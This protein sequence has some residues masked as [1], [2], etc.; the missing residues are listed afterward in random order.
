MRRSSW[1]G[2]VS[3]PALTQESMCWTSPPAGLTAW[4]ST[5]SYIT[6]GEERS[7]IM[8]VAGVQHGVI[9]TNMFLQ[10]S[11]KMDNVLCLHSCPCISVHLVQIALTSCNTSSVPSY[12]P[13]WDI[14][15]CSGN[16]P[17]EVFAYFTYVLWLNVN[18][19]KTRPTASNTNSWSLNGVCACVCV[20]AHIITHA[21]WQEVRLTG[22]RLPG[23][24]T[25]LDL[26]CL[27]LPCGCLHTLGVCV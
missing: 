24:C 3:A 25:P 7:W 26:L 4:L 15:C 22:Q 13:C 9:F 18:H 27:R 11:D 19:L 21:K 12:V 6:S 17:L 23:V 16:L 5:A 8:E 1:V 2:S 20:C 14:C 10:W